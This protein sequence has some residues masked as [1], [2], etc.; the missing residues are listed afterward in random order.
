[1]FSLPSCAVCVARG[2]LSVVR[3]EGRA[4]LEPSVGVCPGD[5]ASCGTS[6]QQ[7]EADDTICIHKG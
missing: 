7:V 3:V 1:M 2:L 4:L 5:G 6:L